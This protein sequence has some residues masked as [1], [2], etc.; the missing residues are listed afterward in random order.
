MTVL[1][2]RRKKEEGRRK[3]EEGRGKFGNGFYNGCNG[4][5]E[6]GKGKREEG[7]GKKEERRRK[8]ENYSL[9]QLKIQNSNLKT[10]PHTTLPTS[11]LAA[12]AIFDVIN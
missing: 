6:E 7:R 9:F 5:Q 12:S 8:R 1:C 3:K 2:F 10:I 4:C 11:C